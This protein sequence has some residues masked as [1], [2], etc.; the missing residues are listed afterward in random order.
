MTHSKPFNLL[1]LLLQEKT[2]VAKRGQKTNIY[3]I[4]KKHSIA[5]LSFFLKKKQRSFMAIF[6]GLN[7]NASTLYGQ[8]KETVYY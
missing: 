8:F 7:L 3:Q 2:E 4:L 6:N 1:S 5:T